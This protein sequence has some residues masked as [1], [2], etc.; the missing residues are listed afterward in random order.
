MS[1]DRDLLY[2]LLP[3]FIRYRDFFEGE[4]L[5]AL[6]AV[7]EQG[8]SLLESDVARLYENW[9]IETC[10]EWVVPYIGELVGVR[11]LGG[12]RQRTL[13]RRARVANAITYRRRKGTV[14][15]LGRVARDA[16]HWYTRPVPRA[17][18]LAVT[19]HLE[20]L[21]PGAGGTADL[22][23]ADALDRLG[24]PFDSIAHAVDV[25]VPNRQPGETRVPAGETAPCG[26]RALALF[27]WRL[28]SYPV[29][30]GTARR[31][32]GGGKRGGAAR[33]T[34]H[35]MGLDMPLFGFPPTAPALDREV[36]EAELPTPLRRLPLS[37]DLAALRRGER[38]PH[39]YFD[40]SAPFRVRVRRRLA[41][42]SRKARREEAPPVLEA[43]DPRAVAI[44]DLGDWQPRAV[45]A[46]PGPRDGEERPPVE[47]LV[48]PVRGRLLFPGG[49]PG[50]EVAVSYR[51]GFSGDL[52]GGP[53]DRG[54]DEASAASWEAVVYRDARRDEE[55][56]A[57]EG[58]SV[59]HFPSLAE[60]LAAWA[61]RPAAE[62]GEGAAGQAE[63]DGPLPATGVVRL[64][65]SATYEAPGGRFRVDLRPGER[66]VI[67]AARERCPCLVGDLTLAGGSDSGLTLCGLWIDGGVR[68]EGG[69]SL[70]LSH[71]T[72]RP[73]SAAPAGSGARRRPS[74]EA[75][76]EVPAALTVSIVRSIL[77]PVRL[78]AW[79]AGVEVLD[80]IV[81]GGDGPAIAGVEAGSYGP[82]GV[83]KH[84]TVLGEVRLAQLALA[85]GVLFVAP[86]TVEQTRFGEVRYSF[87]PAPSRT[88]RRFRCQPDLALDGGADPGRRRAVLLRLAPRFTSASY[89][90]PGYC[91][92]SRGV[93]PEIGRG[94]EDGSEM[95]AFHH[96]DQP[97][98]EADLGTV[99]EEFLPWGLD[100]HIAYVT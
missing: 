12:A 28:D 87:L 88:P 82:P 69:A 67:E 27:V 32:R 95:G 33:Y 52:G 72:L 4:P 10:E 14:P 41:A 49:A 36:Q 40:G 93:A 70:R 99:L 50:S 98:R 7:L 96:L 39:G 58:E 91:Q 38:P 45:I 15:V 79:I 57:G 29:A 13:S 74:L 51:Y 5:R 62:A 37:E 6:M 26:L 81:E 86:V 11:G 42:G 56:G 35:P 89:G 19:Q 68:I 21:R 1:T 85:E 92:L 24:G 55:T 3:E 97:R 84:T 64:C 75:G 78:P 66:L 34:F 71:S 77:G 8:Y 44:A 46:D 73:P 63:G 22:R 18:L 90:R 100:A 20:H 25:K 48:D 23:R 80:S 2:R 31:L 30:V 65:D 47:V 61:D 60:A 9:F 53:Y 43:I 94:A 76:P 16:T 17:R 54:E 83:L 59:H